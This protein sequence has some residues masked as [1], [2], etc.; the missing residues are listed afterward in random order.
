VLAALGC[1]VLQV[2]AITFHVSRGEAVV[3][4]LNFVLLALSLFVLWGR[5]RKA[6]IAS[7]QF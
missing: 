4:P 2:F 1:T 3:T 6:P 7:R 5:G